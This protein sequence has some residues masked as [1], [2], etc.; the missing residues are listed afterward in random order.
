MH[1]AKIIIT[2]NKNKKNGENLH[3][4]SNN[5]DSHHQNDFSDKAKSL[6]IVLFHNLA[7][8]VD[9]SS[10][11]VLCGDIRLAV[12][13]LT[14]RSITRGDPVEHKI[15]KTRST[16][17]GFSYSVAWDYANGFSVG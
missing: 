6:I 10:L 5:A 16:R 8:L 1:A 12:L 13:R 4:F 14:G 17:A 9:D 15:G 3:F 7:R 11:I 2:L